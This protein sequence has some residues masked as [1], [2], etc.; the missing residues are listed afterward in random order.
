M[1]ATPAVRARFAQN[2]PDKLSLK[3]NNTQ[4]WA[5]GVTIELCSACCLQ[6]KRMNNGGTAP[7]RNRALTFNLP[8]IN[9]QNRGVFDCSVGPPRLEGFQHTSTTA[10]PRQEQAVPQGEA[11]PSACNAADY[12]AGNATC[13]LED[14]LAGAAPY[15]PWSR[16]QR[17][18]SK[19]H[20]GGTPA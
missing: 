16:M 12:R 7:T 14:T 11:T 15:R 6:S 10:S 18:E 8:I 5:Y 4:R 1:F 20:A 13:G 19:L 9:G 17:R 2:R 3:R